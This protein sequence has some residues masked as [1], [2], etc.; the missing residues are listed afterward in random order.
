[1]KECMRRVLSFS[2]I[3]LG[4][5]CLCSCSVG[6]K[7]TSQQSEDY[8]RGYANAMDQC[9]QMCEEAVQDFID[10]IEYT[11]T[12]N[13]VALML[14]ENAIHYV[15]EACEWHPEEALCIIQAYERGEKYYGS[16][17]ITAED[18]QEAIHS[19]CRFYNYFYEREYE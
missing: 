11:D 5:L 2:L 9:D 18:Y 17:P 15:R 12:Y 10:D 6:S 4:A 16:Y 3:I 14:E 1:M 7:D 8:R 19:I 13:D